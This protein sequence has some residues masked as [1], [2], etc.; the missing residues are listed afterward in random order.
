MKVLFNNFVRKYQNNKKDINLA[1]E[2]VF[3]NGWFI[4]GPELENFEKNL[5]AY[6]D[7]D[8][9]IGVNSG[10]DAIFLALK[11]LNIGTGDEVITVANTATPTIS[12][13]R[14][15]GAVPI[16]VDI[17]PND[18]NINIALI[19]DKISKK[20]KAILPVHLYGRPSNMT[21]ILSLAKKY[22]LYVVEDVAQS[23]GARYKNK[24]VGAFGDVACF[25]F[26][27]TKNLGA[28]GDAGA[29]TTKNKSLALKIKALRN[30][31]EEFKFHNIYEGY[32]SRL[33][34]IQAAFLNI[35]LKKVD[36]W[37]QRRREI[38]DMYLIGLKNLPVILPP[39]NDKIYQ[40]VWHLFVIRC[41][42]REEFRD[43]LSKNGIQTG[44]HYPKP[45]FQQ[46]VYSFLK[47]KNQNLPETVKIM[48][49]I[50]SLPIYPELKNSEIHY[51]IK[52]IKNFFVNN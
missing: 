9:A 26:Y 32:N 15:A 44:V 39:K 5:A 46:P 14:M 6:L 33:D 52:V 50:V 48:E 47:I 29:I 35:D 34:E 28:F 17:D 19:E 7:V 51:V 22:D 10:T 27:P 36:K 23:F 18:F 13:I 41:Q 37:N 25:S 45:I 30:Y 3:K 43:F 1:I 11:A 8:Y 2:K 20:T 38:A 21:K 31:G 16:F 12:A 49:E 4:L 40:A 24:K 42:N